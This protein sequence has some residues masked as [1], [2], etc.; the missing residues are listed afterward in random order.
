MGG[1]LAKLADSGQRSLL[2]DL[3][4]GEP[5]EFAEP[6]A[7][8]QQGATPRGC[9]RRGL[10]EPAGRQEAP[11]A[12]LL[13]PAYVYVGPGETHWIGQ[14]CSVLDSSTSDDETSLVVLTCGCRAR[15]A[16]SAMR[17]PNSAL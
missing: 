10:G 13:L 17:P 15:A 11:F 6:C 4:D 1:T 14:R 12:R 2:V 9:S 16:T 7:R 5:T 3:T 8:A